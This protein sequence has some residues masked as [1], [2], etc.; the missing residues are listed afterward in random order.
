MLKPK[1]SILLSNQNIND[2]KE[3]INNWLH[4]GIKVFWFGSGDEVDELVS[5]HEAF[6]KAFLL[7]AFVVD[8]N[9]IKGIVVDGNDPENIAGKL[10]EI[11]PEFN[12][13]QFK[14][15]HCRADANIVVQ[16]SAGTGKTTVMVDRI[17]YLIHTVPELH[18]YD[19]YMITFTNDATNQMNIRLQNALMTRYRLTKQQKYLRWLEEQSQMNISTIH[20]FAYD[21]LKEFGIGESFTKN[22]SIQNYVYE[23]QELVKDLIDEYIHDNSSVQS[24]L[25]VPFYQARPMIEDFWEQFAT[26]GISHQQITKMDWGIPV[27]ERSQVFQ[28]LMIKL[29]KRLDDDFFDIKRNNDAISLNDIMRDLQEILLGQNLSLPDITMKYLFIDEFQDSDISQIVVACCMAKLLGARL[30]V[31]GDVKQSIYRFRGANEKAF[32]MYLR[33]VK[34]MKLDKPERFILVNNY[35]T[36]ANI[37]NK[38]DKY[39]Y[40]WSTQNLLEYEK[41]VVPFNKDHGTFKVIDGY[42]HKDEEFEKQV[43]EIVKNALDDL[44]DRVDKSDKEVKEKDRVVVLT[45]TNRELKMVSRIL[46]RNK[47]PTDVKREGSFYK[48][49]AVRDF[50]AM[51]C[52]YMFSDEPKYIF[53]YLLTPYAG[54]IDTIDINEMER[55]NG[56]YDDLVDYLDN[57][58]S[59]TPW[60]R[61]YKELRLRPVLSVLKEMVETES[62]IE[63]YI[64]KSKAEKTADGWEEKACIAAT[65]QDAQQYQADLE[66]L[67]QIL[68]SNIAGDKVTLFEVYNFLR[69]MIATNRDEGEPNI[70]SVDDYHSVLCMTV[71][72][73]KGL[74]F[75]TVIIPYTTRR[76]TGREYTRILIDPA[77]NEVGWVYFPDKRSKNYIMCNDLYDKLL[78]EENMMTC[79]EETRILYV[80]MTRAIKNLTCITYETKYN[81]SWSTLLREVGIDE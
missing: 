4:S 60:K 30:F 29:V 40:A 63:Y 11:R 17:L 65:R 53:N 26:L 3:Q 46:K 42:Y 8:D 59:S 32:D 62:V 39:F 10:V 6:S 77:T 67:L 31:V 16:A 51:I 69:L 38:M 64:M 58:L 73:S 37:M 56:E 35:R 41:P 57:S 2:Y 50:Y 70:K 43:V 74:E 81:E 21:M 45:R 25:G 23:K 28:N 15:E 71:H 47:I 79:M 54:N 76:F 48:S 34:E 24:Q 55:L 44:V 22:L 68:Q 20:S 14:V 61:Y 33:L 18:L 12:E 52:S 19:I 7:Q 9:S 27:D 75:D 36:C 1:Y 78:E 66:K 13:A 5:E 80:A 49:E 72:K